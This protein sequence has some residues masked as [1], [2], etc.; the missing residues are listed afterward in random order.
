MKAS[1]LSQMIADG[2]SNV[3]VIAVILLKD[4]GRQFTGGFNL[5]FGLKM[6]EVYPLTA[7]PK[8]SSVN[9]SMRSRH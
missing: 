5:F 4:F 2:S 6:T 8:A 3:V 1:Y 9:V 7:M